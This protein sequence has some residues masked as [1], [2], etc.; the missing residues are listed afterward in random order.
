[1]WTVT[2]VKDGTYERVTTVSNDNPTATP[3]TDYHKADA[4]AAKS[5]RMVPVRL[6]AKGYRIDGTA[7]RLYA[8]I[9]PIVRGGH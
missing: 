3:T 6:Y 8:S 1:M 4:L 7:I 9:S 5:N 2:N